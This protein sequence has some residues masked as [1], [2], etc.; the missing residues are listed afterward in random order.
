MNVLEETNSS[1]Q[2]LED[3]DL[4]LLELFLDG[5]SLYKVQLIIHHLK[6]AKLNKSR[7]YKDILLYGPKG[8]GKFTLAQ[9][10]SKEA[11]WNFLVLDAKHLDQLLEKEDEAC[12]NKYLK[13][14]T[15]NIEDA[16]TNYKEN[17]II[18]TLKHILLIAKKLRPTA[19]FLHN[20][21]NMFDNDET[22]ALAL[23]LEAFK[24]FRPSNVFM[25]ASLNCTELPNHKL[26]TEFA[27]AIPIGLPNFQKRCDIVSFYIKKYKILDEIS[28]AM[29]DAV[30]TATDNF[31]G[32][33]LEEVI[34][35]THC[36][37][38]ANIEN[39]GKVSSYFI[40]S[41]NID[42]KNRK[43]DS[44]IGVICIP[45]I[46]PLTCLFR[47]FISKETEYL[48]TFCSIQQDEINRRKNLALQ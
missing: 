4:P 41:N 24:K 30:I 3:R 23:F 26:I 39:T 40:A 47:S 12:P 29:F 42:I 38:T 1:F 7:V 48:F 19:L 32:S 25:I 11:T 5:L 16:D 9:I 45:I 21:E 31:S 10:I 15:Q 20:I 17:Q 18:K 14:T 33:D 37:I 13:F 27:K 8:T 34:Y 44:L 36:A 43:I 28:P 22:P 6:K 35:N 46:L 2:T